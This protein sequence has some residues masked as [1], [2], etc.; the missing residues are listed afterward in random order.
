MQAEEPFRA[1]FSTSPSTPVDAPPAGDAR[2]KVY[3]GQHKRIEMPAPGSIHRLLLD[4]VGT[5]K[6]VLEFGCGTG[7]MSRIMNDLGCQ[8]TGVDIDAR[9]AAVAASC[10]E[11][12]VVADIDALVLTDRFATESFDVVLFG[13]VLEHLRN[14]WRVLDETRA[15]LARGGFIAIAIPNVAH[16][17]I[18]LS[19]LDGSFPYRSEGLLDDAHL[20]FFTLRSLRE[21]CFTAGYRIDSIDRTKLALFAESDLVPAVREKNF[22]AA[23]IEKITADPEHDT[24]AFVVRATPIPEARRFA[25]AVGEFFAMERERDDA[26]AALA[27]FEAT[28]ASAI[29]E[30]VAAASGTTEQVEKLESALR[31]ARM[32]IKELES[33]LALSKT[34]L[35]DL[36]AEYTAALDKFLVY[37]ESELLAARTQARELDNAIAAIVKS[38]FWFPKRLLQKL[39]RR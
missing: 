21:M 24:F 27:G 26:R 38:P 12:I 6:R 4:H 16:G 5:G 19:L 22:S 29:E 17:A 25:Y 28:M 7:T 8:V 20:R 23:V 9:A 30:A 10:C 15:L 39:R 33:S 32:R 2:F 36:R 18:R 11:D 1:R 13:E 14:P 3:P 31:T 35:K 34:E 37:A